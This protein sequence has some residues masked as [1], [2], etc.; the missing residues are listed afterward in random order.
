MIPVSNVAK[1]SEG[2]CVAHL[3][4]QYAYDRHKRAGHQQSR[5]DFLSL[6]GDQIKKKNRENC[7]RKQ[8]DA[9]AK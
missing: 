9:A 2:A 4:N 8:T 5:D 1:A 3:K 7:H 6:H